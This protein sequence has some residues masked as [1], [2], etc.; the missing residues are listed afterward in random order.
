M[1]DEFGKEQSPGEGQR[2]NDYLVIPLA[3]KYHVGDFGIDTGMGAFKGVREWEAVMGKQTHWLAWVNSKL[4]Y[5][6][7]D[8]AEVPAIPET[9]IDW[10][11]A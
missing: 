10:T 6:I 9:E 3:A 5:D 1:I 11:L 4:D 2:Q 8:L 7:F